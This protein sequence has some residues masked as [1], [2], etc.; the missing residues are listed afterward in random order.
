MVP[1]DYLDFDCPGGVRWCR[2]VALC[3]SAGFVSHFYRWRLARFGQEDGPHPVISRS[4]SLSN[5][6][7]L[8]P[9]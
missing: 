5:S 4:D 7:T 2:G 9:S 3:Y 8:P 6:V 1:G